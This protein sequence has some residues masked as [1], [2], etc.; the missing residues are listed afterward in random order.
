MSVEYKKAHETY[1]ALADKARNGDPQAKA[2]KAK[3]MQDIRAIERASAR[4][5]KVLSATYKGNSVVVDAAETRSKRSLQDEYVHKFDG[6]SKVNI[7]GKEQTLREFHSKR[8][9]GR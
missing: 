1:R 9:L 3:A 5:G 6:E 4:E 2:D 7:N 8:L